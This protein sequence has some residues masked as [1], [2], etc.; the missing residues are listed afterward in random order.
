MRI[1]GEFDENSDLDLSE[2]IRFAS[3]IV[4]KQGDR[5]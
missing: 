2:E 1:R 5:P 3:Y 4:V